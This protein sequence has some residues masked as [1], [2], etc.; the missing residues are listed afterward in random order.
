MLPGLIDLA[1]ELVGGSVIA[2]SDEFFAPTNMQPEQTGQ[3]ILDRGGGIA[4]EAG[5]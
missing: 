4:A 1:S 2:A 5:G 3:P